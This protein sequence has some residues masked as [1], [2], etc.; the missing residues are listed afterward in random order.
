MLHG[1]DLHQRKGRHLA[2]DRGHPAGRRRTC[3]RA[4]RL[5]RPARCQPDLGRPAHFLGDEKGPE[6]GNGPSPRTPTPAA[7]RTS[8]P[9]G[10]PA[11]RATFGDLLAYV[12]NDGG[13]QPGWKAD[14]KVKPTL[15]FPIRLAWDTGRRATA[16]RCHKLLEPLFEEVYREIEADGLTRT[17]KTDRGCHGFRPKHNG[18]KPSTHSCRIAIDPNPNTNPMGTTGDM[19]PRLVEVFGGHGFTRGGRWNRRNKDP[20]HFQY[21]S[22]Y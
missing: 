1:Q 13:A 18:V 21:C 2:Q 5:Q 20:M 16:V 17:V 22:D 6:A 14:Y 12:S 10:F 15:P 4:G 19:G 7:R 8:P 11:L 9:H 3:C